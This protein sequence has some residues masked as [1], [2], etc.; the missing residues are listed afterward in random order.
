MTLRDRE[1]ER[2]QASL[3]AV[4]EVEKELED[5]QRLAEK[6]PSMIQNMGLAGT[7]AFLLSKK[8]QEK[9]LADHLSRWL[10]DPRIV[11]WPA[12]AVPPAAPPNAESGADAERLGRTIGAEATDALVYRLA[13]REARHYAGWLK[14]WSR[15]RMGGVELGADGEPT[16]EAG[17]A[18]AVSPTGGG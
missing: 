14:R 13:A 18:P 4:R 2:A 16:D 8:K 6:L 5:Y 12:A 17:E 7:L 15:A 11:P 3:D 1:Q 9:R 10:L